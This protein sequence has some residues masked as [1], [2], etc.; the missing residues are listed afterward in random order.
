MTSLQENVRQRRAT[1]PTDLACVSL[2]PGCSALVVSQWRGATWVL[3]WSQFT[4]AQLMGSG[5]DSPLQLTFTHCLLVLSG[6]NLHGLVAD[7]AAFRIG[8]LRDLPAQY[9]PPVGEVAPYVASVEVRPSTSGSREM[10]A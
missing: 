8:C 6:T 2:Q 1:E 7:L 9:C 5:S 10:P 4:G 3:P